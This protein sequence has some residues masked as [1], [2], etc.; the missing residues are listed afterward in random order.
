MG[1]AIK[2]QLEKTW[3]PFDPVIP[4]LGSSTVEEAVHLDRHLSVL[5]LKG[6]EGELVGATLE[7]KLWRHWGTSYFGDVKIRVLASR[8]GGVEMFNLGEW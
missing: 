4:V 6:P 2:K 5:L 7:W 1:C 8:R 3:V